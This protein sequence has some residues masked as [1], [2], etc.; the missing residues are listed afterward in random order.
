MDGICILGVITGLSAIFVTIVEVLYEIN[1][2]NKKWSAIRQFA[3][4]ISSG[5]WVATAIVF[6]FAIFA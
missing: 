4:T 6:G 1:Y 5:F 2:C 3:Y